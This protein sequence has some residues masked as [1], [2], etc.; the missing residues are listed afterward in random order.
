[1]DCRIYVSRTA[2]AATSIFTAIAA[3]STCNRGFV[4]HRTSAPS[5]TI[6]AIATVRV[7]VTSAPS[8]TGATIAAIIARSA[9]AAICRHPKCRRSSAIQTRSI[10]ARAASTCST[11]TDNNWIRRARSD[12]YICLRDMAT[13][14]ASRESTATAATAKNVDFI[15][16]NVVWGL[17]CSTTQKLNIAKMLKVSKC[18]PVKN[19]I[20]KRFCSK[21][22]FL[23][24]FILEQTGFIQRGALLCRLVRPGHIVGVGLSGHWGQRYPARIK[25]YSV[26]H[27]VSFQVSPAYKSPEKN[28]AC[29]MLMM[30][31][32][33][34]SRISSMLLALT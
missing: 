17:P 16:N 6:A 9:V 29:V 34:S 11:G 22:V 2:S 19:I 13:S 15:A 4:I 21:S 14:T 10:A 8:A 24:C 5:A 1:M 30:S 33:R 7:R 28:Q 26:L 12:N 20:R 31:W 25:W 32:S 18:K 23:G 27:S 3:F